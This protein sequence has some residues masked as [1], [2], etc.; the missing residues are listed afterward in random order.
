MAVTVRM[1][2]NFALEVIVIMAIAVKVKASMPLAV[3]VTDFSFGCNR[4]SVQGS[5]CGSDCNSD[6]YFVCYCVSVQGNGCG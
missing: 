4:E 5:G 1:T 6:F 3:I 2:V